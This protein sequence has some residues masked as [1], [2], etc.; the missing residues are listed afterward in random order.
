M[1][2]L[3]KKN[4]IDLPSPKKQ[5]S[6]NLEL[7]RIVSMFAIVAH[8]FVVNSGVTANFDFN[9]I[10]ANMVFLQLFGMWGKTAINS[11]V[12]ISGYFMCTSYLTVKLIGLERYI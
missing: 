3:L 1:S 12:M 6:S 11:F 10:T 8:H 2:E 9:K 5:R 4:S 7:L